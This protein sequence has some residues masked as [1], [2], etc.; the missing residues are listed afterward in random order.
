MPD[1]QLPDDQEQ[2]RASLFPGM[3]SADYA[4]MVE[5]QRDEFA[6][7]PKSQRA[8]CADAVEKIGSNAKYWADT[9]I[10]R[11]KRNQKT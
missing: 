1:F 8:Q 10:R 2:I 5:R 3:S 4:A 6:G 9:A 7:L 11:A